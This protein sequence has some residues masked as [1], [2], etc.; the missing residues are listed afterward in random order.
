MQTQN[1]AEADANND[2]VTDPFV[3]I[4]SGL[5]APSTNLFEIE[6]E[7]LHLDLGESA[8]GLDVMISSMGSNYALGLFSLSIGPDC[9]GDG[10][11][12]DACGSS[13]LSLSFADIGGVSFSDPLTVT[14]TPG[15][16]SNPYGVPTFS[17]T[18]PQDILGSASLT[19]SYADAQVPAPA[20]LALF[21]LGIA[22]LGWSRRKNV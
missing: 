11:S 21:G 10:P 18:A 16:S 15:A 19:L 7:F 2:G 12:F 9:G 13:N 1:S 8:E 5:A 20:T 6:L 17:G 4:F 14:L 22:G 3:F